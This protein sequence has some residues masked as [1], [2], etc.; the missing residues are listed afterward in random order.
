[1]YFSQTMGRRLLKLPLKWLSENTSLTMVFVIPPLLGVEE[2]NSRLDNLFAV[3][4]NLHSFLY[5]LKNS[6]ETFCK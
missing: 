5:D 6:L 2:W 3:P 1:M 4:S